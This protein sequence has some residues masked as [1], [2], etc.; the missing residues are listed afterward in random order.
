[1]ALDD[2]IANVT[3][4]FRDAGIW[5]DTLLIFTTDNGGHPPTSGSNWPLRG[6]KNT[7]WEGGVRGTSFIRGAGIPAKLQNT[8]NLSL[9]HAIDWFPTIITGVL[10]EST[11]DSKPL[12]G[13]NQWASLTQGVPSGRTEI[14]LNLDRETNFTAL[15]YENWKIVVGAQAYDGWFPLAPELP[16]SPAKDNTV[17]LFDLSIDPNEKNDVSVQNLDMVEKLLA[18]IES[19]S[20]TAV[21]SIRP[22]DDPRADPDNFNG[23]WSPWE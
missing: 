22:K 5:D 12:D 23:A 19:Y 2:T 14:L 4:A 1:M 15:R 18:R 9:M 6:G 3:Q 16:I 21:H 8:T 11:N 7:L 20:Q 17:S 10:G 13:V